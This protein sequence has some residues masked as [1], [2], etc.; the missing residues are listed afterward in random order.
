MCPGIA[1]FTHEKVMFLSLSLSSFPF[2]LLL[3]LRETLTRSNSIP[4]QHL[5]VLSTIPISLIL[6]S[7]QVV[8]NLNDSWTRG[9]T[10]SNSGSL[11]VLLYYSAPYFSFNT[12]SFASLRK[13]KSTKTGSCWIVIKNFFRIIQMCERSPRP[14]CDDAEKQMIIYS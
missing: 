5:Q 2:L 3:L 9:S 13:C 10:V 4:K 12:C 6:A 14:L 7:L 11:T 1:L 8:L